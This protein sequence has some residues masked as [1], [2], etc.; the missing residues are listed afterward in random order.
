MASNG[1]ATE[2]TLAVVSDRDIVVVRQA[3]KDLAS[4][5]GFTASDL[6]V[7]ATAIS[8]IGRNVV[9]YAGQGEVRASLV[10]HNGR[11][12]IRIET[13]DGGPGIPDPAFALVDGFSTSGSLGLGLPGAR[14]LMDE[15]ELESAPGAGT[16]VRMTKWVR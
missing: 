14:R 15:F 8:E 7:I 10:S 6:T 11:R 16:T 2:L 13:V 12:G 9:A 5:L 3:C 1:P 4:R